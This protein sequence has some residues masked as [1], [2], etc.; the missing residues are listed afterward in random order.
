M[1][2]NISRY[3]KPQESSFNRTANV[4]AIIFFCVI[5]VL[6]FMPVLLVIMAS[7]SSEESLT[8]YGY[9][10]IPKEFSLES[11]KYLFRQYFTQ[12]GT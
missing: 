10:F 9:R 6:A 12:S 8:Q 5:I 2:K 1:A 4:I 3:I 11:F 7:V